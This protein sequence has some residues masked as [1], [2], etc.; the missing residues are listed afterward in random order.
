MRLVGIIM[1]IIFFGIPIGIFALVM[2]KVLKDSRKDAW[3]G[4]VTDKTFFEKRDDEYRNKFH[5]FYTIVFTTTT[6]LTRK[7][8]V[9]ASDYPKWNKGDKVRKEKG[10]LVPERIT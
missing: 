7:M 2:K 6:G 5:K 8:A 3:E 4:E 10:K 9:T 1:F